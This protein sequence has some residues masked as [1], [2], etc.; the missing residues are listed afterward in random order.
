MVTAGLSRRN[1]RM[2]SS[3]SSTLSSTS[4]ISAFCIW[5]GRFA[6]RCAAW[7]DQ[8]RSL[9]VLELGAQPRHRLRVQLAHAR[10]GHAQH[11]ADFAKIEVLLVV[12]A[13]QD[14]FA[15]GQALDGL[16]QA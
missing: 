13:H 4:R 9:P 15:L 1:A 10:L 3:A 5:L 2:V 8:A 6:G 16:D 11:L 12:Q 7:L 14:L